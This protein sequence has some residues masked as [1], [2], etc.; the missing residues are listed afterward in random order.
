MRVSKG[1]ECEQLTMHGDNI[2]CLLGYHVSYPFQGIQ[3]VRDCTITIEAAV[4]PMA[5][6]GTQM[7]PMAVHVMGPY[8]GSMP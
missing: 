5:D 2:G 8:V 1:K 6:R 3:H 7:G 4:C